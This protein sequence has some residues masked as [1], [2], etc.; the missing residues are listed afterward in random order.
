MLPFAGR[1]IIVDRE[2]QARKVPGLIAVTESGMV[3]LANELHP[4]KALGPMVVTE[5][6]MVMLVNELH[7]EKEL[8]WMVLHPDEST[9][10]VI[11]DLEK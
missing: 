11:D 10:V 9:T 1:N 8:A 4:A 7:L 3:M 5:S 2:V 6:G